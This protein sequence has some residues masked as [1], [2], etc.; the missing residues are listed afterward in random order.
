[1][2]WSH[3]CASIVVT[4]TLQGLQVPSDF[5]EKGEMRGYHS[6][7]C[8]MP[9]LL[10]LPSELTLLPKTLLFILEGPG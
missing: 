2:T 5:R 3:F 10:G 7:P 6:L 1:M 9:T 8:L 4:D